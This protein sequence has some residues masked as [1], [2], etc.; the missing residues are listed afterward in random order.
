MNKRQKKKRYKQIVSTKG[1]AYYFN[2]FYKN[3]SQDNNDKLKSFTHLFEQTLE[4]GCNDRAKCL[5]AN[6][7]YSVI[8]GKKIYKEC[9]QEFL[10]YMRE[11][12]IR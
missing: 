11:N 5:Y 12:G 7:V 10:D 4:W 9:E 6:A 3:K 8:S 2:H 1:Y